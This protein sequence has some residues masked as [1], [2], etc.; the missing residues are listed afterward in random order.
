M[1]PF[2][3]FSAKYKQRNSTDIMLTMDVCTFISL[4]NAVGRGD[5]SLF[6]YVSA[7]VIILQ[8]TGKR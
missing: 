7:L 3:P 8:K 6:I 2:T 5:I 1:G 4:I